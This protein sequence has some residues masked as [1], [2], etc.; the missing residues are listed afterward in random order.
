M[1]A[2][3]LALRKREGCSVTTVFF[4]LMED[5]SLRM[6][7]D[8]RKANRY[9]RRPVAPMVTSEG[10]PN[11]ELDPAEADQRW[12]MTSGNLRNSF[13][14]LAY[15]AALGRHFSLPALS[16]KTAGLVGRRV[17]ARTLALS[18]LVSPFSPRRCPRISTGRSASHNCRVQHPA[19]HP[20]HLGSEFAC[21]VVQ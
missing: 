9:F 21:L 2:D 6:I 8:A 10:F 17:E 12:F 20:C 7:L 15:S 16:A 19:L 11:I 1:G 18:D 5:S 4:V 13:R 14:L 3:W